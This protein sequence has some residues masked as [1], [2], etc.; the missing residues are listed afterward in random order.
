MLTSVIEF[1]DTKHVQGEKE[2]FITVKN[3]F[4]EGL[5]TWEAKGDL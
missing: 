1:Q 5:T 4:P 2:L 3:L